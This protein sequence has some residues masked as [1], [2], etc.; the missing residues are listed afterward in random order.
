MHC[1]LCKGLAKACNAICTMHCGNAFENACKPLCTMHWQGALEMHAMQCTMQSAN[2]FENACKP[3]CTLQYRRCANGAPCFANVFCQR[4]GLF[5]QRL[6]TTLPCAYADNAL[7]PT[8]NAKIAKVG[9]V[10]IPRTPRAYAR[11]E[12][13]R[14]RLAVGYS[15][16]R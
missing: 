12:G 16:L 3:S 9:L 5:C 4:C 7:R 14:G 11:R 6:P 2:A 1:A 10:H 13:H 15:S 8:I